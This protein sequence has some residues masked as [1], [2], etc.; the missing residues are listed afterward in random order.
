VAGDRIAYYA[1]GAEGKSQIFVIASDGSDQ[2]PNPAKRP[3]QVTSLPKGAGPGLRWHPSGN[4]IV[5]T[6]NGGVVATCVQP[7]A[8]FG[9]S[10]FLTPQGDGPSRGQ[11][12]MSRDGKLLAY[13]RALP[14][15]DDSGK[16]F[17]TYKGS[18]PMQVFVLPCPGQ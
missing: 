7:G 14:T 1:D 6:S 2:D 13:G 16:P 12:V 18:D 8:A 10:V 5:C 3:V 15:K 11:L 9:R 17:K 4:L